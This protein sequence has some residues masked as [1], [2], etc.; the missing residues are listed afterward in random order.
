M[1]KK[2]LF[3]LMNN[4]NFGYDCRNISDYCLFSL[5][6]DEIEELRYLRKYQNAFDPKLSEFVSCE[7][8]GN[9]INETFGNKTAAL[10]YDDYFF[11]GKERLYR[12]RQK[13]PDL[14]LLIL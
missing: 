1:L 13:N 12:N 14:I 4:S 3:K 8:L 6:I 7:L 2:I 9:E 11:S 5:I 10:S